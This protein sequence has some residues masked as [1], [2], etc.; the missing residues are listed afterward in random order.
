MEVYLVHIHT[1]SGDDYYS[2]YGYLPKTKD[3][4]KGLW[5]D[6]GKCDDLENY[7]A[8]TI[9]NIEKRTVVEKEKK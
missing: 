8:D 3:I 5:E 1:G 6:E 2:V 4:I 9:V 7:M